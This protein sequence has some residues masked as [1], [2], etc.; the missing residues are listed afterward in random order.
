MI[1]VTWS[2]TDTFVTYVIRYIE[3][4]KLEDNG[5]TRRLGDV[6]VATAERVA[7]RSDE[8]VYCKLC[9]AGPYRNATQITRHFE[10]H[11]WHEIKDIFRELKSARKAE[12]K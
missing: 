7:M 1:R 2:R 12:V 11:H 4:R 6:I 5:V 8:G 9:G 10:R 3:K